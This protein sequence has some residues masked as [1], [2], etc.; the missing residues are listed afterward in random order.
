MSTEQSVTRG[1]R[2]HPPLTVALLAIHVRPGASGSNQP[3]VAGLLRGLAALDPASIRVRVFAPR[4][5]DEWPPA[6]PPGPLEFAPVR[7]LPLGTQLSR[8]VG[9]WW[10]AARE[11]PDVFLFPG[12]TAAIIARAPQVSVVHW[13]NRLFPRSAT[14]AKHHVN[15]FM[16]RLMRA[17]AA[18][19]VVPTA[20]YARFVHEHWGIDLD[21]LVA[22]H[23]GVDL[24]P[25]LVAVPAAERQGV[26]AVLSDMP[27]KKLPVLLHAWETVLRAP[28]PPV[29]LTLVGPV[30]AA[31]LDESGTPWRAWEA[32]GILRRHVRLPHSDVMAAIARAR[33][34]VS[35]SEAE[36]FCMPLAEAMAVGTPVVVADTPVARE[37]CGDAAVYARPRDPADL[38]RA[39]L[40]MAADAELRGQMAERGLARSRAFSW[41]EGAHALLGV[42]ATAAAQ[43]RARSTTAPEA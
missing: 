12:T 27:H 19:V 15:G 32:A 33:L 17:R 35:P 23:H 18:K 4:W 25:S 16:L 31:S 37:V 11:H 10:V 24:P 34:L 1:K 36:T 40:E 8:L 20:S 28:S 13:D 38:A 43:R 6:G 14:R 30:S 22:I 3:Y 5:L 29:P 26:I 9:E 21:R 2:D 7:L 41:E 39:M 42:L